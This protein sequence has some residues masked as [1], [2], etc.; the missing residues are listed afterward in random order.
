M[1]ELNKI[2]AEF[3]GKNVQ[4]AS[5]SVDTDSAKLQKFIDS[6]KFHFEDLTLKNIKYKNAILNFLDKKPLNFENTTQAIPLTYLVKNGKVIHKITGG[7]YATELRNLINDN[8]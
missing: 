6:K 7:T 4:F 3:E 5:L 2:K 8:L 1:P